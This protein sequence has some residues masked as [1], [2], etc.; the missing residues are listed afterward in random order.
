MDDVP[1]GRHSL[2]RQS[3]LYKIETDIDVAHA[4]DEFG[5]IDETRD[6]RGIT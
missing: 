1:Q 4:P 3:T 5:S 2:G 6:L